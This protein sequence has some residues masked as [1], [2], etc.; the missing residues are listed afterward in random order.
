[1]SKLI[2]AVALAAV[3]MGATG[4]SA[5]IKKVAAKAPTC[6]ACKMTLATTKSKANPKMV[7]IAGKTYY[8]CAACKMDAPKKK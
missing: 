8:C 7:K 4:A 5:A 3:L 6:S 1:M 2:Q